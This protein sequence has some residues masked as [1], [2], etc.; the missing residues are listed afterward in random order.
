MDEGSFSSSTSCSRDWR[1]NPPTALALEHYNQLPKD[2]RQQFVD[3]VKKLTETGVYSAQPPSVS[4]RKLVKSE[5][6][7]AVAR[8][9]T[10]DLAQGE[11]A[12]V[13]AIILPYLSV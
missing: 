4:E 6:E 1:E 3:K 5:E 9:S 7:A 8:Q 11:L 10:G 13:L 12:Y 2:S